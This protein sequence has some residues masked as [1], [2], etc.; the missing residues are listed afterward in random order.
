MTLADTFS[1]IYRNNVWGHGSGVGSLPEG[2]VDYRRVLEGLIRSKDIKTVLDYGC[3]DWQ[4]SRLVDWNNLVTKYTGV[5]VVDF[6]VDDHK[7]NFSSN[8]VGFDL[9][10]DHWCFF[11]VD[12]IIC[13]D[14]FQHLPNSIV[15]SVLGEMLQH[16]RYILL[17]ND[18]QGPSNDKSP[19][20]DCAIGDWRP[21]DFSLPPW[22]LKNEKLLEWSDSAAAKKH[23][24]LVRGDLP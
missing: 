22:E 18:V 24:I 20:C 11:D 23:T 14:V 17:T 2:T 16:S 19:N 13:K 3:G 15:S 5:D 1:T 7:K 10:D 8:V 4:F 21:L 12:L 9:R 6:L